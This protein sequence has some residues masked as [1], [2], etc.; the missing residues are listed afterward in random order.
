MCEIKK[1]NK[2]LKKLMLAYLF[3]IESTFHNSSFLIVWKA[4]S[5]IYLV[6][7]LFTTLMLFPVDSD[8]CSHVEGGVLR[9]SVW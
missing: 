5:E 6:K 1:T 9:S 4:K 2:L 7:A 3:S 8:V